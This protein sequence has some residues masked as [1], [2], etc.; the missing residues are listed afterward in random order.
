MNFSG[1]T[2]QPLVAKRLRE[3]EIDLGAALLKPNGRSTAHTL[4][5]VALPAIEVRRDLIPV[6]CPADQAMTQQRRI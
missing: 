5:F 3:S 1:T 6:V 2:T 4:T